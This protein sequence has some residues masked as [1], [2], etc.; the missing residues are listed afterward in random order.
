MIDENKELDTNELRALF[1]EE[2]QMLAPVM[3]EISEEET[4]INENVG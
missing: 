1:Y 2:S 4:E 3:E